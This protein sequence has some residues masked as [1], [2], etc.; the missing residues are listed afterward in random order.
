M[1]IITDP[2]K[3]GAHPPPGGELTYKAVEGPADIV[4]VTHEHPDHN[5]VA[6]VKGSPDIVR[7]AELRKTG[8]RKV[9]GIEFNVLP[10]HHDGADGEILGENNMVFFQMDG[11]KICHTGDI[12]H[13]LMDEQAAKL[14]AVDILLLCVGLLVPLGERQFVAGVSGPGNFYWLDHIIDA[15]VANQ[16]TEQLKPKVL[17]P[18]HYS[19]DKCS[20]KLVGIN[21]YLKGK[22]NVILAGKAEANIN[23]DDLAGDARIIV[24]EPAL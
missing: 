5:N 8:P 3:P 13:R 12:G 20:F 16:I 6:S 7:G 10:C 2:F 14:G 17:F 23:P 1:R 18:I 19:N 22:S 9:R 4:V 15:D 11:M 21:E 24:L